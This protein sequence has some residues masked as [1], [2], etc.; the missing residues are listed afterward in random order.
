[1]RRSLNALSGALRV[2]LFLKAMPRSTGF[3][4]KYVITK[5][6][7]RSLSPPSQKQFKNVRDRAQPFLTT[8]KRVPVEGIH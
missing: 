7:G 6:H 2:V 8:E 4:K 5:I 3:R 1:M